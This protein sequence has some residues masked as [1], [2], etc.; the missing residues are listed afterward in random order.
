[1]HNTEYSEEPKINILVVDDEPLV[2]RSLS[3]FLTLEGYAVSSAS[4]GREAINMLKDYIADIVITDIKM[5]E[6]DGLALLREIKKSFASTAVIFI[7]GYGSIENAV[8]AMKEGAFDYITKPIIDNEIR[9]V[10]Q[11]LVKQQQ[12]IEENAKLKDE[13]SAVSRDHFLDIVGKDVKMQKIY[14]LIEAIATTRSTVLINGES[15]TGKHMIAHAIHQYNE[16]ERGKPFVEV[17]CGA[18]TETLL[19][20]ELF[21]HVKGAFTGAIKDKMGRFELANGGTIF[22]D[23]IDTC[24]PS[25][26]VKLLRV[27]QEGEFERVGES[28][29]VKVDVRVIAA[30]NQDLQVLIDEGKFRN[31]LY[32]RLNI[33]QIVIPPLR[34]RKGD[35]PLL[36]N[37][38]IVKHAKRVSKKIDG[39]T[40]KALSILINHNW[41]GN[42]RE[43]ENVIE[44]AII[45]TKGPM[46]TPE[47]FPDTLIV[48][49]RDD[50]D[51][52]RRLKDALKDPEKD[53][54]IKALD[55]VDW[56][57]NEAAKNL[58]INRT[59]LY[60]KMLKYGLLKQRR[61]AEK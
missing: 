50:P 59:T 12:L 56:N 46:I 52:A 8:E 2:R 10:L 47:D 28:S 22:L 25:L 44:R 1:M 13:I 16:Q 4:N 19:E 30:T 39:I 27:L 21:G 24:T 23:E 40:N 29:T 7:T 60:K 20:S 37:D 41:P 38:F 3:E 58:G 6:M 15:G 18:L 51:E 53:I 33:I 34:E 17:S 54:I 45:L 36:V 26:Q 14:G 55:L 61:L 31:D 9:L 57:R 48:N 32:Y 43:L 11:R 35:I 49:G 5:P 42:I